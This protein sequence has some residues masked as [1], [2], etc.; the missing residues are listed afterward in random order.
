MAIVV[1]S[2]FPDPSEFVNCNCNDNVTDE[3]LYLVP[4]GGTILNSTSV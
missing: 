3:G 2:I 4:F 1:A